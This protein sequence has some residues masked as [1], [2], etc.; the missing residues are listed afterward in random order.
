MRVDVEPDGEYRCTLTDVPEVESELFATALDEALSPIL[1]PRYV[2]PR[3]TLTSVPTG[4][5][6]AVQA[7]FGRVRLTGEVWHPVPSL[8]GVNADRA[9][10]F[11]RAWQHWVG[12][13]EPVYTGSPEGAGVLAAQAG[14]DPF[15]VT[16]VI[17]RHW[18]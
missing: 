5:W 2:V 13:G 9:R 8:L 6:P 15:D 18:E 7:S 14:A 11:G 4:W 17:R 3:W 10:H 12:G 16:T 1:K